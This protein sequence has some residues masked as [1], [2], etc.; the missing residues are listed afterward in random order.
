MVIDNKHGGHRCGRLQV[1]ERTYIRAMVIDNKP[2]WVIGLP[3]REGLRGLADPKLTS[4]Y[5]LALV[6]L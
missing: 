3:K 5:Q 1:G 4:L 6:L 2:T